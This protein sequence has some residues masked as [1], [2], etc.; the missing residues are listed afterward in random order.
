MYLGRIVELAD[1][2]TL[3]AQ[4]LHPYTEALLSAVPVPDPAQ[5]G[6]QAHRA[7]GR[8]AEPDEPARRLPLP[9]ALPLCRGPLPERDPAA[10]R[11]RARASGRLPPALTYA[12]GKP[13]HRG[14]AAHL[15]RP[16]RPAGGEPRRGR[17]VEGAAL[18]RA[19]GGG[20]DPRLG[21]RGAGRRGGAPS[22]RASRC[23]RRRDAMRSRRRS[24]RRCSPAGSSLAAGS[25]RRW[26]MSLAPVQPGDPILL[27]PDGTAARPRPRR[28]VRSRGGALRGARARRD[29]RPHPRAGRAS[30]LQGGRGEKPR[31]RPT[32][33]IWFLMVQKCSPHAPRRPRPDRAP[34]S[35][36]APRARSRAAGALAALLELAVALCRRARR[37]R[38]LIGP[39]SRWCSTTSRA[40]PAKLP[41]ALRRLGRPRP[42]RSARGSVPSVR[43]RSVPRPPPANF[44]CAE[45]AAR[46][47]GDRA[48]GVSG[49]SAP[50]AGAPCIAFTLR[51]LAWREDFGNESLWAAR[52]RQAG[53]PARR[54][55]ALAAASP[56]DERSAPLRSRIRLPA[57]MRSAPPGSTRSFS[58]RGLRP[59][60]LIPAQADA[61]RPSTAS[62]AARSAPTAG[63]G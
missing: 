1:A 5:R 18:A 45:A 13:G 24:P 58:V 6:A 22:P 37:L 2:T 56:R 33:N 44:R 52:A 21:A 55:R 41:A 36:D 26:T 10:A 38:R 4:P 57:G 40:S 19:R 29:W 48:P 63:S 11:T 30:R 17:R 53:R 50:L 31:W 47:R 60:P 54:R 35:W 16:R 34:S 14:C 43:R 49:R 20:P 12:H 23:S 25:P 59:A 28:A 42:M 27:D 15:R 61:G 7:A 3:F 9:H 46:R 62:S 32:W 39:A 8:R 51:L